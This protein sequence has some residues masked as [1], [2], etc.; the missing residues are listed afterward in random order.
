MKRGSP[1]SSTTGTAALQFGV[2]PAL[3]DELFMIGHIKPSGSLKRVKILPLFLKADEA[4][5]SLD[6][7]ASARGLCEEPTEVKS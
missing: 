2:V 4:Q 3:N 5:K 1:Y 7:F 6:E